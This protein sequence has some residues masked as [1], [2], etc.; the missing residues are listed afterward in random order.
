M[1]APVI[2]HSTSCD[3]SVLSFKS[4]WL[5]SWRKLCISPL[6]SGISSCFGV[7]FNICCVC[8]GGGGI[9]VSPSSAW[10]VLPAEMYPGG[11][12]GWGASPCWIMDRGEEGMRADLE[13]TYPPPSPSLPISP[14]FSFPSL[15]SHHPRV[16]LAWMGM[17][18]DVSLSLSVFAVFL[19]LVTLSSLSPSSLPAQVS[20]GK[21]KMIEV[22]SAETGLQMLWKG[23]KDRVSWFFSTVNIQQCSAS[24]CF[25]LL[26]F[27]SFLPPKHGKCTVR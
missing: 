8:T 20:A 3:I 7:W 9:F 12:C 19:S 21:V 22:H 2:K 6:S 11:W 27:D 25:S 1:W 26:L 16:A 4:V 15:P 10:S 14:I 17:T 18:G 5:N 23:D 24:I 13:G